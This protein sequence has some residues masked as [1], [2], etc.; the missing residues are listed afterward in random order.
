MVDRF[1][2]DWRS[3]GFGTPTDAL[4]TFTEKMTRHPAK[5]GEQDVAELRAA[6]WDDRAVHDAAQVCSYFN[7]IN[8]VADALGVEPEDWIDE[9]GRVIEPG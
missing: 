4:L 1:A 2:V 7:Y 5:C 3:A 8:R 9:L 6:G